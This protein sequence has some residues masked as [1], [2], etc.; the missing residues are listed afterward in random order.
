[1]PTTRSPL[2]PLASAAR[3]RGRSVILTLAGVTLLVGTGSLRP[4]RAAAAEAP[5]AAPAAAGGGGVHEVKSYLVNKLARMDA[6][7][8]SFLGQAEDYQRLLDASGGDYNR[9]ATEH[10]SEML[11]LIRAMQDDYRVYHNQG[12]ETVEGIV[13]GVRRMV[14]FDVYLDAGVPKGEASTDS[15]AS[16]LVLR[17]R[18][19]R[20]ISDRNGN[21][22]HFVIEPTLWGTKE[23]FVVRL[24]AEAAARVK[25]VSV[26]PRADVLLAAATDCAKKLDELNAVAN[27]WQPTLDEC[28]GALVWMTPTLNGYF[29]DWRDSRYNPDASLGKFVAQSRVLDMR[30]I[31]SSLQITCQAILPELARKDPA[32]AN[33]LRTEYA[34]ILNFIARVD[35]REKRAAGKLTAGEIEE[36]ATQAKRLTDQLVPHLRQMAAVLSL[37]LP[38]KPTLA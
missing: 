19:G 21:L 1:M 33:R 32:L 7:G 9:A 3:P 13:A 12:Y 4:P 16:P 22:F 18:E 29:D 17:S 23:N 2:A 15:P 27:R 24:S 8:H 25:P 37:R 6:A 26:L 20:I 38:P 14:D 30:G 35:E 36:L 11:G 5:A 10:G 28:V 31:M 34:E